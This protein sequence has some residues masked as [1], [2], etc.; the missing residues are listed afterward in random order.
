[1]H[2]TA[3]CLDVIN[4]FKSVFQDK[5]LVEEAKQPSTILGKRSRPGD[6]ISASNGWDA[7]E[8]PQ[9]LLAAEPKN[10]PTTAR[11]SK[12]MMKSQKIR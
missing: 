6:L 5:S 7:V 9:K 10:N 11:Q 3:T 4:I 1:M 12:L 8:P 2:S